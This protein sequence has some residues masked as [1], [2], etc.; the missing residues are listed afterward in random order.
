MDEKGKHMPREDRAPSGKT[1]NKKYTKRQ[2]LF[3]CGFH[4]EEEAQK[5][6]SSLLCKSD[7]AIISHMYMMANDSEVSS[8]R[9][10]VDDRDNIHGEDAGSK[11]FSESC[12]V[13]WRK[14]TVS[15]E[16]TFAFSGKHKEIWTQEV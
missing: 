4:S 7:I 6:S 8:V 10:V 5:A 12:A 3:R 2:R 9:A 16:S 1:E 15:H 11:G 14:F 13:I